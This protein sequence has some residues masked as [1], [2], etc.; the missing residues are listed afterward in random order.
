[1]YKQ[2]CKQLRGCKT[3]SKLKVQQTSSKTG[4]KIIIKNTL[5]E[6]DIY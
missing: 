2:K 6:S 5:L 1:M 3:A 4:L